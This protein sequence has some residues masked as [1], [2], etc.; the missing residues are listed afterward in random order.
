KFTERGEVVL[1]ATVEVQND[2]EQ[3]DNQVTVGFRIADTGIGMRPDEIARLFQA[4]AQAD[5][6]TTRKYGGT[7]LGLIISKQLVELMG[8]KIGV[9]SLAGL[10]STFWF[11]AVFGTAEPEVAQPVTGGVG[12]RS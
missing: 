9:H 3:N 10:G 1:E 7:G 6:S 4:F 8:G 5:T 12:Q 2:R 11:T